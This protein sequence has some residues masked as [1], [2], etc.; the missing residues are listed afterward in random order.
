MV[1]QG[2]AAAILGGAGAASWVI[3]VLARRAID[4]REL[5]ANCAHVLVS[6]PCNGWNP[7]LR[8]QLCPYQRPDYEAVARR[9][10]ER[11]ALRCPH[12]GEP[13]HS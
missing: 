6:D 12:C 3:T 5:I 1:D 9:K 7:T 11:E 4:R 8:C 2:T 10:A 13:V